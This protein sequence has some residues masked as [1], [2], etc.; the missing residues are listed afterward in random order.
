MFSPSSVNVMPFDP[1]R[2]CDHARGYA[3]KYASKPEKWYV[4]EVTKNGLKDWLK[5]RTVGL[6][7]VFNRILNFHVVRS[8]RPCQYTPACFI[9]KKEYRNL[10]DP[11]HV[12]RTPDYP[13]PKYYLNYTQKYFFRHA[14]LRHLRVEQVRDFF[15]LRLPHASPV[16]PSNPEKCPVQSLLVHGRRGGI[17]CAGDAGGHDGQRRGTSAS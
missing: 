7:M 12:Q 9:G 10:R 13:D 3:T 4:I 15:F 6:C 8:T 17:V 5:S 16:P 11:G 2:G 14:S 1:Q